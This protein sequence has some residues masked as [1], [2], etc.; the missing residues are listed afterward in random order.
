MLLAVDIGNTNIVF[1]LFAGDR[2][3]TDW[4]IQTERH[5]TTDEYWVLVNEFIS[6]NQAT[7]GSIKDIVISCV[8]PPLVPVF[9]ELGV[10]YFDSE[11][12]FVG[13]GMKTGNSIL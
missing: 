11:P 8:V 12:L 9:E 13:P 3:Q 7:P 6:L 2:L 1:G 5:R 10:K 4:R